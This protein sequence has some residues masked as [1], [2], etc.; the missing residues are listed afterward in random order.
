LINLSS[1][2]S[3]AGTSSGGFAAKALVV[4]AVKQQLTRKQRWARLRQF[5]RVI[6]TFA[7]S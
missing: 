3:R 5:G 6:E 7:G 4:S 2:S 1:A